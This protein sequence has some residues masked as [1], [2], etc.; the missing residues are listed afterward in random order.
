MLKNRNTWTTNKPFTI[1]KQTAGVYVGITTEGRRIYS[2]CAS[3]ED[4]T[5]RLKVGLRQNESLRY[6]YL[7]K[8]D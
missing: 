1:A 4:A 7:H 5:L 2:Y 3:K 8:D 6:A